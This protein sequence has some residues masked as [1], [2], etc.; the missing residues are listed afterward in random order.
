M[1]MGRGAAAVLAACIAAA[2]CD[3]GG[4]AKSAGGGAGDDDTTSVGISP[5]SAKK[6]DQMLRDSGVTVDTQRVDSGQVRP[7]GVDEQ[8]PDT[9]P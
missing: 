3:R 1:Q 5:D 8:E 2:A 6:I 4:A 9:T 7:E